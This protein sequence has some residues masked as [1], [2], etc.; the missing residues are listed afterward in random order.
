MPACD[1]YELP[2]RSA[3][4]S[5]VVLFDVF[6]H[7]RAPNA[8]LR[9]ARRVLGPAGRLI[10]FEPYISW[11]S[12]PIYGLLHHEPMGEAN[13]P[14]RVAA[15]AARLVRRAG[16]RDAF[17][18]PAGNPQLAGGLEDISRGRIQLLPLLVIGRLQQARILPGRMAGGPA[19]D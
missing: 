8:F 9:E 15:A 6:H 18:F 17:V 16:Q 11:T 4:L 14:R 1:G 2:F 7:L 13:Q 12:Y 19:E 3:S 10:L 5:H